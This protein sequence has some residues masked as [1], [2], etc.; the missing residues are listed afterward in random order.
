MKRYSKGLDLSADEPTDSVADALFTATQRKVMGLMFR[1]PQRSF[2]LNE[3]VRSVGAGTGAVQRE[4]AKLERAGLLQMER[5]GNQTHYQVNEDAPIY[6]ELRGIILKTVGL[7]DVLREA[8]A[9]IADRISAAFVYGSSAAGTER[10]SSDVDLLII[11]S[12]IPLSDAVEPLMTAAQTIGREINPVVV[13][14]DEWRSALDDEHSF[15]SRIFGRPR[16]FVFGT[17]DEL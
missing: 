5:I 8:L 2:Y 15:A 13:S 3:V 12:S 6:G 7:V 14:T 16:L 17:E 4:L 9:P 1:H 11:G 10:A